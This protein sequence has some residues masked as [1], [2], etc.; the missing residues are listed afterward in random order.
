MWGNGMRKTVILACEKKEKRWR[1]GG[2][3]VLCF[4][5]VLPAGESPAAA[6]FARMGKEICAHAEKVLFP[7]ASA[8]L[9]NAV[10]AGRGYA[11]T[12][13]T[14]RLWAQ[15]RPLKGMLCITLSLTVA[16]GTE[17]SRNEVLSTYWSADGALQLRKPRFLLRAGGES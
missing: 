15:I 8:E 12:P 14:V 7:A 5:S 16:Q 10:L 6:H 4:Q 11:F 9:E 17:I 13:K 3:V 2:R 1:H